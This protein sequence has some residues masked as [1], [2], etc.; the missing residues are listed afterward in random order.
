MRFLPTKKMSAVMKIN[1]KHIL[2]DQLIVVCDI[3][4]VVVVFVFLDLEYSVCWGACVYYYSISSRGV[5]C[6]LQ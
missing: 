4:C 1:M 6:R 5:L 2:T 3:S